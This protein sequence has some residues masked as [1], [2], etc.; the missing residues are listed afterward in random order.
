MNSF[1]MVTCFLQTARVPF[2][3]PGDSPS[4]RLWWAVLVGEL[5]VVESPLPPG[6]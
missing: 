6:L 1:R 2:L 4:L 5:G 3:P